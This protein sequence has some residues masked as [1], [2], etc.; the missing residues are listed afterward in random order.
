MIKA[1]IGLL[2][3]TCVGLAHSA[4]LTVSVGPAN[5]PR[6][7]VYM[8]LYVEECERQVA[9]P[10]G[11]ANVLPGLSSDGNGCQGA[12]TGMAEIRAFLNAQVAT[13]TTVLQT[14][15]DRHMKNQED[16]IR[17]ALADELAGMIV[18]L[19]PQERKAV[20]DQIESLMAN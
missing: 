20:R 13:V 5:S 1:M 17:K 8:R 2:L 9:R 16:R 19:T 4:E 15:I 11:A 14:Y 7:D 6:D 12:P 3:L 10:G 18:T